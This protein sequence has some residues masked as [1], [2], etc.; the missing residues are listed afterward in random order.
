MNWKRIAE[1]IQRII[2][3]LRGKKPKPPPEPPKPVDPTVDLPKP[4][5]PPKP[6]ADSEKYKAGPNIIAHGK[7]GFLWKA[8]SENTGKP[9]ILLPPRFSNKTGGAITINGKTIKTKGIGNGYREHYSLT[10][11]VDGA[12]TVVATA[13]DGIGGSRSIRWTWHIPDGRARWDSNIT[14]SMDIL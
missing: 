4:P 2:D 13:T 8:E 14:P 3:D 1:N 6:D 12:A 10:A 7:S 11:H 5:E 9:V